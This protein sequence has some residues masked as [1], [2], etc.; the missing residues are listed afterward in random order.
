M[1]SLEKITEFLNDDSLMDQSKLDK[2]FELLYPE[3]KSIA[4]N[5]LNRTHNLK[6]ITPTVLVN[7]C[8]IKLTNAVSLNLKS[9]KHFYSLVA[10]CIRFYLVDLIRKQYNLINQEKCQL[11]QTQITADESFEAEVLD[12]DY[13]L[14]KLENIDKELMNIVELRFFS[15]FSLHEI[16]DILGSNKSKIYRQWLLAKSILVNFIDELNEKKT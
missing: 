16:A 15:G 6:G 10:R 4:H 12:L 8:Y 9:R 5:Q 11:S 7:E 3:I 1:Q 14:N 13:A 2:V